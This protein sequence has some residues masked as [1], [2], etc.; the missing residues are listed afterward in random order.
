MIVFQLG[1]AKISS[2]VSCFMPEDLF[3]SENT[4]LSSIDAPSMESYKLVTSY[5]VSSF[6]DEIKQQ[7]QS[8]I[9]E[10]DSKLSAAQCIDSH[11]NFY[12]PVG[13]E[14]GKQ[15]YRMLSAYVEEE[16]GEPLAELSKSKYIKDENGDFQEVVPND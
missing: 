7:L 4:D 8:K 3:D 6:V 13:I 16:T 10:L 5:A 2:H 9:D 1:Q 11:G 12:M 14:D 15:T